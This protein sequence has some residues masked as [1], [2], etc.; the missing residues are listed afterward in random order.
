MLSAELRLRAAD[1]IRQ[2]G[3]RHRIRLR[4]T[5]GW[6]SSESDTINRQAYIPR[7]GTTVLDYRVALH[8][9]GHQVDLASRSWERKY[10]SGRG[11]SYP[12]LMMESGG[13]AWAIKTAK[14]SILEKATKT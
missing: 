3:E 2:L 1:H 5:K 6:H 10:D 7:R 8:E 11:E 12:R 13:W 4:W 14:P 9:I